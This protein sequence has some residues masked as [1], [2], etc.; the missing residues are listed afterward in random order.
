MTDLSPN[1]APTSDQP[2]LIR[3]IL[4]VVVGGVVALALTVVTDNTLGAHGVLTGEGGTAT[5][6][7][8]AAYRALF[9]VVGCHMAARLA[10]VG[11]PRIR[12]AMGLGALMLVV[13]VIGALSLWGQVPMWYSLSGIALPIPC[14]IVGGGTAARVMARAARRT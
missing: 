5:M 13:N 6:L 7:M 10:P 11:Q 1:P 9:S 8:A 4:P 3:H 2:A 14:A 12:Y